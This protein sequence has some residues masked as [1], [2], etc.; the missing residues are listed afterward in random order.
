MKMKKDKIFKKLVNLQV[1]A[2]VLQILSAAFIMDINLF[3]TTI[4]G[5]CANS[6][7]CSDQS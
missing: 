2:Y 3:I 5:Y 6:T 7:E 4:S 1:A